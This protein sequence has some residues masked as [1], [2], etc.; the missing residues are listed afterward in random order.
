MIYRWLFPLIGCL[1]RKPSGTEQVNPYRTKPHIATIGLFSQKSGNEIMPLLSPAVNNSLC[2]HAGLYP[3]LSACLCDVA[4]SSKK[5]ATLYTPWAHW[6]YSAGT[7]SLIAQLAFTG[8]CGE[9]HVTPSLS[10]D[11]FPGTQ[12]RL[13]WYGIIKFHHDAKSS[14]W[15]H[16]YHSPLVASWSSFL[17]YPWTLPS[18]IPNTKTPSVV[19]SWS[20]DC[21]PFVH[22]STGAHLSWHL[23]VHSVFPPVNSL[24]PVTTPH[25]QSFQFLIF[26]CSVSTQPYSAMGL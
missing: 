13:D 9:Y 22:D 10:L 20:Q 4:A 23:C 14:P 2:L 7:H 25:L 18:W 5:H 11:L 8:W 17:S 1:L 3:D 6:Q 24:H 26:L 12:D 16:C 15:P 19:C 21:L